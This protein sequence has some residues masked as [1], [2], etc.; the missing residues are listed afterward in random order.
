MIF[1]VLVL[2][3]TYKNQR[4]EVVVQKS[5]VV[6][7]E[8]T[9]TTAEEKTVGQVQEQPTATP[10]PKDKKAT[11]VSFG[12]TLCHS[13]IFKTVFIVLRLTIMIFHQCF[14]M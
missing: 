5:M 11:I 7:Q 10:R 4:N 9:L 3:A 2:G 6:S 8:T 14:N 12:D 13:Q 1:C